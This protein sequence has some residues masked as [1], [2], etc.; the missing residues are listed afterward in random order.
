MEHSLPWA[1]LDGL[2][3]QLNVALRNFDCLS[4]LELL[5]ALVAEYRPSDGLHDLVWNAQFPVQVP[6]SEVVSG[7]VTAL[8][9][10]RAAKT[11]A[12]PGAKG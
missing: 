1:Q 7:K 10:R 2:L 11:A 4:V 5:Q 9:S 12:M 6:V 8:P 3:G